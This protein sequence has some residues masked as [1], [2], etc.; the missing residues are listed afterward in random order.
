MGPAGAGNP[1]TK[2]RKRTVTRQGTRTMVVGAE[3]PLRRRMPR[4]VVGRHL[5]S[6]P[7]TG[8]AWT[9]K[10]SAARH[11]W[12][13]RPGTQRVGAPGEGRPGCSTPYLRAEGS[14]CSVFWRSARRR[15]Y[16]AIFGNQPT[17]SSVPSNFRPDERWRAT[18]LRGRSQSDNY[19]KVHSL[20]IAGRAMR[21]ISGIRSASRSGRRE[22]WPVQSPYR[23]AA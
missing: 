19:R 11:L 20:S 8:A 13:E 14:R 16:A 5:G 9:N 12:S 6:L 15:D 3:S 2:E 21:I 23:R 10:F 22:G 1:W 17:P 4:G 18:E 7:G